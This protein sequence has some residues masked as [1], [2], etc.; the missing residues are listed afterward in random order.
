MYRSNIDELNDQF[1]LEYPGLAQ[2]I[3]EQLY[4]DADHGL[5]ITNIEKHDVINQSATTFYGEGDDE[6][7][8]NFRDGNMDGFRITSYGR[9]TNPSKRYRTSTKFVLDPRLKNAAESV[10]STP[11][12]KAI[13]QEALQW[14]NANQYQVQEKANQYSYDMFFSPTNLIA[15]HYRQYREHHNLVIETETVEIE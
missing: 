13:Y 8:I 5:Y 12:D 6:I 1:D 10:L 11:S 7:V 4:G 9:D 3:A 14:Y 2:K 15:Q